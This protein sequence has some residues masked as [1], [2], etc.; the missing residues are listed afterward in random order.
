MKFVQQN[1]MDFLWNR[2]FSWCRN[3]NVPE[4]LGYAHLK[5]QANPLDCEFLCNKSG[6]TDKVLQGSYS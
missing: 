1:S 5:Q 3:S 2:L 6:I 4:I